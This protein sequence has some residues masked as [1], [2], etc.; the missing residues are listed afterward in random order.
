MT[1]ISKQSGIAKLFRKSKIIIWDEVSMIK[2]QT[3]ERV[4]RRFKDIMDISKSFDGKAMIFGGDFS[5][6]VT[7]SSKIN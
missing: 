1:N 5:I 2:R 3:I 4:D 7:S 6:Y